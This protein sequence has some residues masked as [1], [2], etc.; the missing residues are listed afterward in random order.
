VNIRAVEVARKEQIGTLKGKPVFEIETKGGFFLICSPNANGINYLGSGSHKKLA[1]HGARK[2]EPEFK[3]T[4]L[5]KSDDVPYEAFARLIPY[6]EAVTAQ[7]N[8]ASKK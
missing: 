2:K 7:L 6:Y 1:R 8:A 3:L 5:E 4:V